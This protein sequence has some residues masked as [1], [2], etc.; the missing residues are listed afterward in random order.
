MSHD[1]KAPTSQTQAMHKHFH[2]QAWRVGFWLA[3]IP[4]PGIT[5]HPGIFRSL[6]F[7]QFVYMCVKVSQLIELHL[8]SLAILDSQLLI[9]HEKVSHA[10]EFMQASG[11]IHITPHSYV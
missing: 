9:D 4:V 5:L 1:K 6:K 11:Y 10:H 3:Q 7:Y 8:P 2:T